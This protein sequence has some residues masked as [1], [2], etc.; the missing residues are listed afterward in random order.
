MPKKPT[1][2]SPPA[3]PQPKPDR[4]EGSGFR[5]LEERPLRGSDGPK[6]PTVKDVLKPRGGSSKKRD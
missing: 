2:P 3:R 6:P 1:K 4:E 5:K